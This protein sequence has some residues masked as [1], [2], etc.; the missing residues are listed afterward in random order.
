M[1]KRVLVIDTGYL[2]DLYR[3]KQNSDEND[4]LEITKRFEQA[5]NQSDI[6]CVPVTVIFELANHIA[7]IRDDNRRKNLAEKLAQHIGTSVTKGKPY[8]IVPCADF[9]SVEI[10]AKNLVEFSKK[11]A[12]QGLGLTDTSVFLEAKRLRRKYPT[13][14]YLVHIWTRDGKLKL[15][16]RELD[17]EPNPFV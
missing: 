9:S 17:T 16:E 5:K 2:F 12:L 1:I 8:T 4:H 13:N 11:Y 14:D 7:H 15:C 3:V 10:L 6:L